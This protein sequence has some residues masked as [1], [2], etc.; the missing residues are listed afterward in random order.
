M[1]KYSTKSNKPKWKS[2]VGLEVHAQIQS[3]S[4][5]F[6]S[7]STEFATA[8]NQNVSL[9]DA[10]IPGTLPVL[11]KRCVEAGVLTALALN[12]RVNPV[13]MFDRKHY[14]YSDLP[15][16]YQITQQ[17]SPLANDGL[18][19]FHVYTPGEHKVPYTMKSKIKQIQLEQD[20]GKS[21][22]DEDRSLVDLNRAGIPLMEIVFEPDLTD[23]EEAAALIKEL[24]A[25]LQRLNTCSCKME[26]GALRVDANVSVH[27]GGDPLGVRTEIKNIGSIRAVAG[28]I[29]YEIKRQIALREESCSI[30]N[31]TRSWNAASKVTV[32]MRDKEEKQDYRYMPEPNLPPLFLAVGPSNWGCVNIDDLKVNLPELPNDTRNRLKVEFN[33]TPEQAV[34]LVNESKLLEIF[35]ETVPKMKLNAKLM[36]NV[37][38]NDFLSLIH[39]EKKVLEDIT[40]P[41]E[42]LSET[43]LLLQNSV[44]NRKTTQL[45]LK[46]MLDVPKQTPNE[47]VKSRGW[48]QISDEQELRSICKA[49]VEENPQLLKKYLNGKLVIFDAFLGKIVVKSEHKA[50]MSKVPSILKD[51]LRKILAR[52]VDNEIL[53]GRIVET[54]CYLGGIDKASHSFGGRRTPGNEPMYMP[55]GTAY[56]YMTYGMYYCF[57]IS[58]TEPGAAVLLRAIEPVQ[59]V[60]KMLK[61]RLSK[62]KNLSK[63]F[64]DHEL[65]NGPSKLCMSMNI[66]KDACNKIDMCTSDSLWIEDD[67]NYENNFKT[68][69]TSRIG[70]QSVGEEWAKKPLRFYILGNTSV[71]RRD[72]SAESNLNE[73]S[74]E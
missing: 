36:A 13:S 64:K 8:V 16:G 15:A 18:L 14:F 67:P 55:P 21:L 65:G 72:R 59:N 46:E 74:N 27:K 9:F 25:I 22:H 47:I 6:S 51:I 66:T 43:V 10:A 30:L 2:V 37:L 3:K 50:D 48:L 29:N 20:S 23:G 61:L 56:V 60:D 5:L 26:E 31:E 45:L 49:V 70:I 40:I 52:K 41:I 69:V 11:N 17:R 4:K 19:Q 71:S 54:E 44:I 12:C 35:N 28:A 24:V 7:S 53:K 57:N 32:A 34:I 62:A 68:V 42:F 1:Q 73:V 33:L 63:Q 39:K 38:I 58:S